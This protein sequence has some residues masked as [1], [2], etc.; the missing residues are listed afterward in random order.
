VRAQDGAET[1]FSLAGEQSDPNGLDYLR[2]RV[3]L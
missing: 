3:P 2:A 1:E